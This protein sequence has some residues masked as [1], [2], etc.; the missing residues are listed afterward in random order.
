[1][2]GA[3]VMRFCVCVCVCVII[4]IRF[5]ASILHAVSRPS[6]KKESS[7]RDVIHESF[8]WNAKETFFATIADEETRSSQLRPRQ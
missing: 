3:R 6:S 5:L 8:I 4:N 2:Y 7:R 1:M